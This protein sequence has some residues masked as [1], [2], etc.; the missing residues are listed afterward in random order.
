MNI[1]QL[2][3]QTGGGAGKAATRLHKGLLSLGQNS[4]LATLQPAIAGTQNTW[5]IEPTRTIGTRLKQRIFQRIQQKAIDTRRTDISTSLFSFPAPG[6]HLHLLP[7][8][9]AADI[10]HLHWV[11]RLQSLATLKELVALKKPIVWTLHD[12]QPFTGGCHYTAGC[13]Q[14]ATDR[15]KRCPQLTSTSWALPHAVLKEKLDIFASANLSIV[16]PSRWLADE[17][18]KS[19]LFRNK[20]VHVI[21]NSVETDIYTP[22]NKEIARHLLNLPTNGFYLLFGSDSQKE[23]RKGFTLMID[24]I[25]RCCTDQSFKEALQIGDIR[26]LAFG[27]GKENIGEL[28]L[29]SLGYLKEDEQLAAAY[30]AADITLLPSLEDNLP[31]ILLESMSCGTP[32]IGFPTGGIPDFITHNKTGKLAKAKNAEALADEILNCFHHRDDL[33]NLSKASRA[34]IEKEAAPA[35]QAKR[36]Q[37][38]YSSLIHPSKVSDHLTAPVNLKVEAPLTFSLGP[39]TGRDI[40]RTLPYWQRILLH[41]FS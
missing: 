29:T 6:I 11:N 2:N 3:A 30:R 5:Q 41:I 21:P 33:H 14:F 1:L 18:K 35:H 40:P 37:S 34:L 23:T 26:L 32:V 15:C 9:Q 36:Y 10:I 27:S 12:A 31:N 17:A 8:I 22:G 39:I 28:P 13:T 38:L 16:T 20:M 25:K 19:E 7:Q 4:H 24:A